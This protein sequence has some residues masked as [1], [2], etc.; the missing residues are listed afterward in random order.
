MSFKNEI[1]TE[2][3]YS[4][5]ALKEATLEEYLEH[6]HEYTDKEQAQH[7]I[8][9]SNVPIY[10]WDIAQYLAHNFNLAWESDFEDFAEGEKD[11]FKM[12]QIR[13]Y[14]ELLEHLHNYESLKYNLETKKND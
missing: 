3:D 5:K 14:F 8:A 9:D 11:I 4:L 7:E 2:T 1:K 13:I 6:V 10:Y 12:I